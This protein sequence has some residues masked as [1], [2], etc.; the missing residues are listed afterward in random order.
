MSALEAPNWLGRVL[1]LGVIAGFPLV[2][3]LSW[4]YDLRVT[5]T[6]SGSS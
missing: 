6:E 1:V 3:V 5:K 4:V 2:L